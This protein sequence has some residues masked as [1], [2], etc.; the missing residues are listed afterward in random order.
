MLN[1]SCFVLTCLT[2][3]LSLQNAVL[4]ENRKQHILGVF[5]THGKYMF[6]LLQEVVHCNHSSN[7]ILANQMTWE[8]E[9]II[10][11]VHIIM[12]NDLFLRRLLIY[13]I[14]KPRYI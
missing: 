5:N 1:A 8:N 7:P 9:A 2:L 4:P 10:H 12:F 3:G 6:M 11:N 14:Y 13:L